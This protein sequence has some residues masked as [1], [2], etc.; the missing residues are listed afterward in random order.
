MVA[1]EAG[2]SGLSKAAR[3]LTGIYASERGYGYGFADY[4]GTRNWVLSGGRLRP[5]YYGRYSET[6]TNSLTHLVH[7]TTMINI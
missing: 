2:D 1:H 7:T 3:Y 6:N 4:Y 5:I